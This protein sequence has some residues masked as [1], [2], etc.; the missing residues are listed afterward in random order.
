VT[1]LVVSAGEFD[2]STLAKHLAQTTRGEDSVALLSV[3]DIPAMAPPGLPPVDYPLASAR[4]WNYLESCGNAHDVRIACGNCEAG[5]CSPLQCA[6]CN[7]PPAVASGRTRDL[8]PDAVHMPG[9]RALD[10][11]PHADSDRSSKRRGRGPI[12]A[13]VASGRPALFKNLISP[14]GREHDIEV[15]EVVT[16]PSTLYLRLEERQ[17]NVLLLDR[18]LLDGLGS[19]SHRMIHRKCP[20]VR[21]LLLADDLS[22]GLVEQILRNKF[23]GLL[24]TRCP[25]DAY[26]KAITAVDRGELWLPRKLLARA[27]SDLLQLADDGA[28]GTEG[29]RTVVDAGG[30]LTARQSQIVQLLRQGFTNKEIGRQLG[31]AE[32]TVKK[33][34]QGVFERLGVRRRSLVVLGQ[35]RLPIHGHRASGLPL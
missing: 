32:D 3:G 6:T 25:R 27:V 22:D 26:V 7:L 11:T 14:P 18:T 19:Q 2:A 35:A 17:P 5:A 28:P 31:I 30:K 15:L 10:G 33:H 23:D 8:V 13:M 16:N 34:L 24:L 4:I 21:V 9:A 12:T 20:G 1:I 29:E